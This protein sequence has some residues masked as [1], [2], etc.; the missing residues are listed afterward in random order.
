LT[1]E[2]K[3]EPTR[4]TRRG[5]LPGRAARGSISPRKATCQVPL[6]LRPPQYD[7]PPWVGFFPEAS[8]VSVAMCML[9]QS[10]D[11]A[12]ERTKGLV[13]GGHHPGIFGE[14]SFSAGA[15]KR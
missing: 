6:K 1:A 10:T 2:D 13:R 5:C 7:C 9:A 11:A 4:I 14:A 3:R 12:A 15:Q 8:P